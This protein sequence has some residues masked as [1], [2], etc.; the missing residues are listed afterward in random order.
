[1]AM[2]L[3]RRYYPVTKLQEGAACAYE[4]GVLTVNYDEL[5]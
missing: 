2:K 1:M 5:L 3:T 4:K